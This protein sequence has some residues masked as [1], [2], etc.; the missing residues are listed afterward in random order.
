VNPNQA[1]GAPAPQDTVTL[2]GQASQGQQTQQNTEQQAP[3]QKTV[4]VVAEAQ[5]QVFARGDNGAAN[6]GAQQTPEAP[7]TAQVQTQTQLQDPAA[8]ALA[9]GNAANTGNAGGTGQTS[10]QELQQLDQTLQQLGINPQSISLFNRLALLLYA[11]DP[12]ALQQFVQQLQQGAQEVGQ[13]TAATAVTS[14]AQPPA[15]NAAP[16][17]NQNVVSGQAGAS[18]Q[19]ATSGQPAPP[20]RI[21]IQFEELQIT[22]AAAGQTQSSSTSGGNSS[23]S[24]A[25]NP[26]SSGG[27][28]GVSLNVTA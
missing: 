10:E 7:P 11:N 3:F 2:T 24:T 20:S 15:Q 1:Q 16:A 8:A 21:F 12:A 18:S 14:Q 23:N 22:F 28:G 4:L 27:A 9:T 25:S 17:Q 19:P 6:T 26:N 5:V 13:G